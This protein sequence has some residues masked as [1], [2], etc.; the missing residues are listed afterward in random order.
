MVGSLASNMQ[1]G[2]TMKLISVSA[3]ILVSICFLI[4][5][6]SPQVYAQKSEAA[7]GKTTE[8]NKSEFS[9]QQL[10]FF[11]NKVRPLLVEHCYQCHG[12][13]ATPLEG[14][15]SLQSRKAML[16]G[17]DTGPAITPGHPE[18]SLLVDAINY[19][20]VYEMPPDTKLADKDIGT[21]TEWVK[22]GAPWPKSSDV[23]VESKSEFDLQGRKSAHWCWKPVRRKTDVPTVE[24]RDWP[25]DPIDNFILHGVEQ[26]GL[27]PAAPADR[28]TLIRCAYFDI[29]GL[30]PTPEKIQAFL[31][32][33]S[34]HAYEKVIDELLASDRFGERWARHWMDL[35]RYAETGGHEFDY[36]IPYA[37]RYRD[38]LIR[39]FNQDVPYRQLIQEHIAG[40]LLPK[41]RRNPETDFD[42]SVL[43]TGFWFLGEAKHGAVDSREE[44]ARTFDNQ[45]DVMSKTFLGLTVACARCHDHKFDAIP[46]EDYYALAGFLQSS[47]RQAAMLDPGRKIEKSFDEATQ[48]AA[49]GDKLV[50]QLT[51]ELEKTD[52]D[53][54]Q[55]YFDG[56]LRFLRANQSWNQNAALVIE[57]E[58]LTKNNA[59]GG[60]VEVQTIKP[61]GG[62]K[63]NGDKQ[64]WW[65]HGKPND[66]W[67]LEFVVP[68]SGNGPWFTVAGVFTKAADYGAAKVSINDS[69]VA[70]RLDF[71][72]PELTTSGILALGELELKPGKNILKIELAEHHPDA[73][74]S[75]MIGIDYLQLVP[76]GNLAGGKDVTIESIATENSIDAQ[77][78]QKLVSAIQN[79]ATANPAH[80][81]H[82]IFKA[83]KSNQDLDSKFSS[84]IKSQSKSRLSNYE[85]WEQDSTLFADFDDGLPGSWFR[86]GF[87]LGDV[88]TDRQPQFAAAGSLISAPG[89]IDSGRLGGN[90]FGV[91]RSPTFELNDKN[92]HYRIRGNNVT[93]RLIINGFTMDEFNALLYSGCKFNIAN[94][95]EF[96]WQTQAG[97]L[98]NH[99][100]SRAHIEIIDHG[101]GYFAIDEIRFSQAQGRPTLQPLSPTLS[102]RPNRLIHWVR[103]VSHW[104]PHLRTN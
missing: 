49:R 98:K 6:Q 92:I 40:D 32:D 2:L 50:S 46:T 84:Q 5:N 58:S 9:D 75:N 93:I 45:I 41:P 71:Y 88:T 25:K 11:E 103:F 16:I 104:R 55:S 20:E 81:L 76:V 43:G 34:P 35:T 14:G 102:L 90:F 21:L 1:I 56:A 68:E 85:K 86:T 64:N 66:T 28:R 24:N 10:E 87:A 83:S 18:K 97:D 52:R 33:E 44:E 27:S 53:R 74:P 78:L 22:Q 39:A 99:L 4:L 77:L 65:K 12:P 31:D 59:S 80:P 95:E 30:P 54:V 47:R 73:I 63:W 37:F 96:T 62:F 7:E 17:G 69:M 19:G 26:A 42:E 82:L 67:E 13:E 94:S 23:A 60:Q 89:T 36:P 8:D 100:G 29:I 70:E 91:L 79:P 48:L 51:G 38:Y 57:G 61:R 3:T 101:N 72:S 15:L